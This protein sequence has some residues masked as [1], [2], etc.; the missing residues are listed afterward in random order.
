MVPFDSITEL[1][2]SEYILSLFNDSNTFSYTIQNSTPDNPEANASTLGLTT[3]MNDN[4]LAT[5]SNLSIARTM[6]HELV[7]AYLNL[8]YSSPFSFDNGMD[9]RLKMEQYAQDNGIQDIQSN[10]FHHDFMGQYINAIAYSLYEWDKEYGTGLGNNDDL[11]WDY[12]YAMSFSG[13]FVV[14]INGNIV[15][16]SDTF[17]ALVPNSSERQQIVNI[18]L[19]EQ[20]NNS[21]AQGTS[22]D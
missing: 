2:F 12:Y 5:A 11:G 4:Y 9:F 6:I 10:E 3:T 17:E 14:D 20:N 21:D 8:R 13:Q 18:I 19:N 15:S 22:C 16:S 7:H 1:N